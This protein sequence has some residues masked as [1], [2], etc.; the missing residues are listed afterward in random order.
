MTTKILCL[1]ADVRTSE[2]KYHQDSQPWLAVLDSLSYRH[3]ASCVM[4]LQLAVP[5]S[6]TVVWDLSWKC[7]II[8]NDITLHSAL[9]TTQ[10]V[11]K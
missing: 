6:C 11:F 10:T 3:I 4:C 9:N 7:S 2:A 1:H 5:V 8:I